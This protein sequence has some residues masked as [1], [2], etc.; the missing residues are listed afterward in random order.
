MGGTRPGADGSLPD[1][2]FQE[3]ARLEAGR[4]DT[5]ADATR[6]GRPPHSTPYVDT[7]GRHAGGERVGAQAGEGWVYPDPR[8]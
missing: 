5:G 2:P 8:P 4:V 7:E 1:H 3:R 6:T